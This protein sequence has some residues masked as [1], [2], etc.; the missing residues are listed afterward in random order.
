MRIEHP[1]LPST[2]SDYIDAV[3]KAYVH[4]REMPRWLVIYVS[5][6]LYTLYSDQCIHSCRFNPGNDQENVFTEPKLNFHNARVKSDP[7]LRGHTIRLVESEYAW[8]R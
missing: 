1:A 8:N 7:D 6:E 5:P 4:T 2:A 3:W